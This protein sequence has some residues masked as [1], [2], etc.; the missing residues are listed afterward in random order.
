MPI[1]I[2]EGCEAVEKARFHHCAY[3]EDGAIEELCTRLENSLKHL[4]I[5]S[6]GDIT[7][8]GLSTITNLK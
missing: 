8:E 7:D 1:H 6:C 4:E 3:L 2:L 5:S